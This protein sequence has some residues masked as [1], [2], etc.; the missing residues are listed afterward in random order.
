MTNPTSGTEPTRRKFLGLVGLGAAAVAGGPMLSACSR[1]PTS[2]G[3]AENLDQISAVLPDQM[4]LDLQLPPPDLEGVPPIADHYTTYPSQLVDAISETPGTSGQ[5]ITAMTPIWQPAVPGIGESAYY[6]AVN[7]ELGT[8][9]NFSLQDGGDT[10]IDKLNATLSA[11]DVPDLLCVPSWEYPRIPRFAQ[12]VEANFE[13]LTPY[14]QGD[15]I[16]AYPMM[17][18]FPVAAWRESVWNGKLMAIP[19]DTSHGF[20]WML[21]ARQDLLDKQGLPIPGSLDELLEMGKEVTRP[22]DSV[23]AFSDIFAMIQM[24]HRVPN[25]KQGWRLNADGTPEFR[26]ETDEFAQALEVMAKI[27]EDGLVHPDLVASEGADAKALFAPNGEIIFTQDG[28]GSWQPAQAEHQKTIE[29]LKVTPVPYLAADGGDPLVWGGAEPI[30][31]CFIKKGLGKERVEELLR[32]IDWCSAPFGTNEFLL[33]ENGAAGD[34]YNMTPEGPSK[35][36]LGF[37]EIA[38]QYFFISGRRPVGTPAPDTPDWPAESMAFNNASVVFR[39]E[40]PWAGIKLELP[41]DY[42]ANL[43]PIEDQFTDVVRGRRPVSD[44]ASIVEE[45]RANGGEAARE[46]LAQA[47]AD[48]GR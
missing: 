24:Y 30:S 38:N 46:L 22:S 18:I 37:K 5:E 27:Y 31:F 6:E 48:A 39:E 34:H 3:S 32:I 29:D 11:R 33:R 14:L 23:W 1:K 10:Y 7:A 26:Y 35:T 20:A 40:D 43:I 42:K 44:A 9:I 8:P 2:S 15:K 47:L 12:A 28:P 17:S 13:D 4:E 41:A 45:W 25:S 19:N 16:A 36:D 21:F